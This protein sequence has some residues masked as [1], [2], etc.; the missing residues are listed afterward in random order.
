MKFRIR[1]AYQI[2]G[3]FVIVGM[4]SLVAILVTV[5]ANQRW[6]A[7][8]YYYRSVF[9][10]AA[11]LSVGM[12]ITFRGFQ[13]G[14]LEKMELTEENDVEIVFHIQDR[15]IHT[16]R[17]NS[18][19]QLISNP[20]GL[21][22]GLVFH[23]GRYPTDP[24]EEYSII[25]SLDSA[26]ARELVA[27]NLVVLPRHEDPITHILDQIDPILENVTTLT[28]TL[29][30]AL[31]EAIRTLRIVNA[32]LDGSSRDGPI[33]ELF[34]G[35]DSLVGELELT[36]RNT[37]A[38]A[39]GILVY[40]EEIAKNVA[41]AT[42]AIADPTGIVPRLLDPSGSIARI[43]DDDE[44]LFDRIDGLLSDLS[45]VTAELTN[46]AQFMNRTTPQLTGILEEGRRAL[47]TGKDVLEG[48]SNNPL[49]RGGIPTQLEPASTFG[50]FRDPEF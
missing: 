45:D 1:F 27:N 35:V 49:I 33:A 25:P 46:L 15:Y 41:L 16:V 19:I 28:T 42:D 18:V 32:T 44:V 10:S 48:L 4:L 50:G 29:D 5:G 8:N 14:R 31:D 13:I 24:P 39:D 12:P 11:G 30:T 40:I 26:A 22:G 6:F 9:P 3:V 2:V 34:G 38:Q 17:E 21:G 43:L 47:A 7:R 36:I 37:V 20:L 23:Q